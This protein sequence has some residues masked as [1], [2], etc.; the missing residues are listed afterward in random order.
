MP[1]DEA[2]PI[3]RRF[4]QSFTRRSFG[5]PPCNCERTLWHD[6]MITVLTETIAQ[7]RLVSL[8]C[9]RC[10]HQVFLDLTVFGF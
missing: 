5:P 3:R 4:E 9:V 8:A 7:P 10:H 2:C 6:W 1:P